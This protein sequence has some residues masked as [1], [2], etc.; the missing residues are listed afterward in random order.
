MFTKQ[1]YSHERRE[2][3]TVAEP[4]GNR[5]KRRRGIRGPHVVLVT[6]WE[7]QLDNVGIVPVVDSSTS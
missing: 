7:L 6:L 1:G 4:K 5:E 3:G 2:S